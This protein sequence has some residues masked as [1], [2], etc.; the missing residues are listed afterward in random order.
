MRVIL[1][2]D[3]GTTGTTVAVMNVRGK[4]L[5]SVNTEFPQ[6]YPKPGWVEQ[7]SRGHLAN[8]AQR[9]SVCPPPGNL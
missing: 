5:G 2:I 9:D 6:I 3:Q 8:S 4:L 1:A 7:R